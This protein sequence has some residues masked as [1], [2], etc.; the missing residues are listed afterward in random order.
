MR[1]I[2][3]ILS[4]AGI[5]NGIAAAS[6][7]L[8]VAITCVDVVGR[9]L[10]SS[11]IKGALELTEVLLCLSIFSALPGLCLRRGHITVDLIDSA[12]RA[13]T[14]AILIVVI[15]VVCAGALLVVS[16]RMYLYSM[17][18]YDY[19]DQTLVLH[20]PLYPLNLLIAVMT[21]FA[22]LATMLLVGRDLRGLFRG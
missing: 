19:G 20:I 22:A 2:R 17:K 6:I 1:A 7:F 15:D 3:G 9:Y 13:R 4:A 14:R 21:L 10:F 8:L 5:L 11:P 18:L 12:V 16:Y